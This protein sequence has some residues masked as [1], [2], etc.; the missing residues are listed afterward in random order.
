MDKKSP[1]SL[2]VFSLMIFG[3]FVLIGRVGNSLVIHDKATLFVEDQICD[4]LHGKVE[5]S[6]CVVKADLS[7]TFLR[8]NPVVRLEDGQVLELQKNSIKAYSFTNSRY[9]TNW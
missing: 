7:Y 9:S 1:F 6:L 2:I 5:D 3:M 8:Q 4:V